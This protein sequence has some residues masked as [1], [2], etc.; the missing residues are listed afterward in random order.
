MKLYYVANAR[1]PSEKA[2]G[3]QIAKMCEAFLRAGVDLTLVVPGR[4]TFAE[5]MRAY[6][7]LADD[8]PTVRIP[9]PHIYEQGPLGFT[10]ASLCFMLGYSV[11]FAIKKLRGEKFFIY[12]VDMDN[13]SSDLLPL[14]APTFT[15]MHTPKNRTLHARLFF[16]QAAGVIATNPLTKETLMRHFGLANDAFLVE[17][18]GVDLAMFAAYSREDA[19]REL[20][21]P[22]EGA[23]AL[24]VGRFY[25]WKG[26]EVLPPACALLLPS[27][28][29]FFVVGGTLEEFKKVSG[30]SDIPDNLHIV[31]PQ[32]SHRIPLWIAASDIVLV[33]G[34]ARND[35]SYRYTSPMKVFEYMAARRPIVASDTPALKAI[36]GEEDAFFY[37]PDNS[38][39][40][41]KVMETAIEKKDEGVGRVACAYE[42][43]QNYSWD[44]RT[45]RILAF[46][47]QQTA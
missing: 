46:I 16:G 35:D 28:A 8:V 23:I 17:P 29:S 41:A 9:T 30:V 42:K 39:S 19:R 10:V 14:F 40:L 33:L 22:A 25:G 6:Y 13:F 7:R 47:E 11:F 3:I 43:I 20:S 45:K 36:L 5:D 38:A 24:Y 2:H 1:M 34:T 21:L 44:M 31:G 15:E 32:E 4:K 27:A 37:E 18:N 26:L 12:T